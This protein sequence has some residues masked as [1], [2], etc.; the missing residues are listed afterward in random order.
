MFYQNAGTGFRG[1]DAR[2]SADVSLSMAAAS[3]Y[4]R[5]MLDGKRG[6]RE[7]A[8]KK[9]VQTKRERMMNHRVVDQIYG[10]WAQVQGIEL[11]D[12]HAFNKN[13]LTGR[14][15]KREAR[16]TK[17]TLKNR[18]DVF[19]AKHGK[20]KPTP[21][22]IPPED[23]FRE[24]ELLEARGYSSGIIKSMR[25]KM[26]RGL[27]HEFT[28]TEAVIYQDL[29]KRSV[30]SVARPV[31]YPT[32]LPPPPDGAA[33]PLQPPGAPPPPPPA[34]PTRLYTPDEKKAMDDGLGVGDMPDDAGGDGLGVGDLPD[35]PEAEP[36][37]AE[38]RPLVSFIPASVRSTFDRIAASV[39]RGAD[40]ETAMSAAEDVVD[41]AIDDGE[42][43]EDDRDKAIALFEE[44]LW[45]EKESDDEVEYK[46]DQP[47]IDPRVESL[48][49]NRMRERIDEQI[50]QRYN[51]Q[52]WDDLHADINGA[53]DD[54]QI[55]DDSVD[56]LYA[57]AKRVSDEQYKR[58]QNRGNLDDETRRMFEEVDDEVNEALAD[59]DRGDNSG[60][61]PQ[62]SRRNKTVEE[63]LLQNAMELYEQQQR[64][65][66]AGDIPTP[67]P[68]RR[69]GKATKFEVIVD[70]DGSMRIVPQ[71]LLAD[72]AEDVP[73]TRKSTKRPN[74]KVAQVQKRKS[75][76][77][78]EKAA[79]RQFDDHSSEIPLELADLPE[80]ALRH[81]GSFNKRSYTNELRQAEAEYKQWS[82]TY[83][84]P[85]EYEQMKFPDKASGKPSVQDALYAEF[86]EAQPDS[87]MTRENFITKPNGKPYKNGWN[88]IVSAYNRG[89]TR[90]NRRTWQLEKI[91]PE[92][93]KASESY[94][95]AISAMYK[96]ERKVL[97]AKLRKNR[98]AKR[99]AN[100]KASSSKDRGKKKQV[101][102]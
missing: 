36:L 3:S 15:G 92:A 9:I 19:N 45:W 90:I 8:P 50:G 71:Q 82:E 13:M 30:D 86:R 7:V 69:R 5:G 52:V 40:K 38:R 62:P 27:L 10:R 101:R 22:E 60:V 4:N 81:I 79:M 65:D 72:S 39:R 18:L 26:Q 53:I 95:N 63:R 25:L 74:V 47:A 21:G 35:D 48:V 75:R 37:R 34:P 24:L 100:L 58:M 33:Y 46:D 42:V 94:R 76:A 51:Q 91:P 66:N 57:E 99:V 12:P 93:H 55:D 20:Q 59:F 44:E 102:K 54:K 49:Y 64:G 6:Q 78:K 23:V 14:R 56:I 2:E 89:R 88:S 11:D 1:S 97:Q 61:I 17:S 70:E 16:Y 96:G 73:T 80:D 43:D 41:I 68:S 98:E 29:L 85:H 32:H 77:D 87:K 84:L 31:Q 28:Q 83:V 67:Q